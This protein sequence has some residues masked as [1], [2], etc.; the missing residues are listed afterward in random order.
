MAAFRELPPRPLGLAVYPAGDGPAALTTHER[1]IEATRLVQDN[2]DF[3]WRLLRRFGLSP[4][5][6]DDVCQQVFMIA[7]QKLNEIS[8][9]HERTYLYGTALRTAANLK[10]KAHRRREHTGTEI[11]EVQDDALL[12]D[13]AAELA[14][15]RR[16]LDELLMS[17]PP[18]LRRVFVLSSVEQFQL[19]EIAELEGVP[20][21]TVASRLRRARALFNQRLQQVPHRK[22]F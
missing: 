8:P 14:A 1:Q 9:G 18:K 10:R 16:L 17:V 15:A 4:E 21:G 5:D 11:A 20:Q 22:P 7:T 19:A 2:F 13:K 6:A 3:I 12:P